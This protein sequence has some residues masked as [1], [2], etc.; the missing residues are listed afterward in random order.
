MAL[1]LYK[2]VLFWGFVLL[3]CAGVRGAFFYQHLH[4]PLQLEASRTVLL[5]PGQSLNHITRSLEM[6]G[7]LAKAIDLRIYARLMGVA[8]Q[9]KA[10]EYVLELEM[11]ALDLLDK[12]V[13]GDVVYHRIVLVEGWTIAEVL[14]ALRAHPMLSQTLDDTELGAL[15]QEL[16]LDEHPEGMFF[17]DTYN[18]T[19][20]TS[21]REILQRAHTRLQEILAEE[22]AGRDMGLP[23]DT[24]YQALIM[25][26]I[27]EKETAVPE[28]RDEIA[29]VFVRRLEA[30]M[31]LQTD[32]TVIYGLGTD[33]DG[34]LS[35]ADLRQPGPYNTYLNRGLPPTP[36]AL[37]GREAISASLHPAPG[38]ALY[39]V[40]RGDG[41][42]Q[43]SDTLEAHNAAVREYQIE[44]RAENYISRP[45]L[46]SDE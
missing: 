13:Q 8:D 3:M 45:S 34:N 10:G 20:G 21:E 39:F 5:E 38:N 7:V 16:E 17:P 33:Y 11:T 25:A 26:S 24:P 43:F 32:P 19:R 14:A 18:F 12:L 4:Q 40:A 1:T 30:N 42:H 46:Q 29:G 27:V 6:E 28:E 44:N 41:S 37:A 22:W 36:I 31:R 2:R 9:V 35:R 23:Y 15:Q